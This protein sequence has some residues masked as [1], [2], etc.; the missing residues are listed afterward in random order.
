MDRDVLTFGLVGA[1]FGAGR[2]LFLAA[3]GVALAPLAINALGAA[4]LGFAVGVIVLALLAF[5]SGFA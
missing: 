1:A 3:P 4:L 2:V 5:L